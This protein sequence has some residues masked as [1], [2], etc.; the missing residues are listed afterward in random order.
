MY[1]VLYQSLNQRWSPFALG[2]KECG[3]FFQAIHAN[4][5]LSCGVRMLKQIGNKKTACNYSLVAVLSKCPYRIWKRQRVCANGLQFVTCHSN[6]LNYKVLIDL[7]KSLIFCRISSDI[8]T[9]CF[10]SCSILLRA[11]SLK[12]T[13]TFTLTSGIS[14]P[15]QRI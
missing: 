3:V 9:A 13:T 15:S 14:A 10:L 4:A 1:L 7:V 12:L 5:L 2:C 6:G 8:G 11:G